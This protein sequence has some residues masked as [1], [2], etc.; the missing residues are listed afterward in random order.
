M[1]AAEA[2]TIVSRAIVAAGPQDQILG[3]D[4]FAQRLATAL[5]ALGI[6]HFAADPQHADASAT[7][8]TSEQAANTEQDQP[9]EWATVRQ[10]T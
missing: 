8:N 7:S 1:T 9:I 5:D 10:R 4:A 6:L 2:A 3:A